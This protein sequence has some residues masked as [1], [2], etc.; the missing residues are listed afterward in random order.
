MLHAAD[1][2]GLLVDREILVDDA[3]AA[4]LGH[5]DGEAGLGDRVHGRGNQRNAE[6]DRLGEAGSGID[7]AGKDFG[8]RRHQQHIV[9]G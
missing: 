2:L 9:E 6:L 8:R 3:H 5:G 1:L 7:L 4:G